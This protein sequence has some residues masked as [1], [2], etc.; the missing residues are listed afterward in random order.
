M[1]V[2]IRLVKD[3]FC[4]NT[5]KI[6]HSFEVQI[7]VQGAE[8]GGSPCESEE[9]QVLERAHSLFIL[10]LADTSGRMPKEVNVS[11]FAGTNPSSLK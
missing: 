1:T 9:D 8:S 5:S 11:S 3:N 7:M 2:G 10:Q 6:R 4:L